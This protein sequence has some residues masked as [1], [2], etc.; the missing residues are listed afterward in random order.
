[1]LKKYFAV[2]IALIMVFTAFA[3]CSK[4]ES[5]ETEVPFGPV[6]WDRDINEHWITDEDGEKLNLGEHEL[7]EIGICAVCKSEI[8]DFGDG[9][10]EIYNYDEQGNLSR[11]SSYTS[12]NQCIDD[13]ENIFE[14]DENGNVVHLEVYQNGFLCG[15]SEFSY[16][17]EGWTYESVVV[18][19]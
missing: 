11:L 5:E 9:F 1:M 14:Y 15:E 10:I 8:I 17:S 12:D 6:K 4:E 2:L 16:S 19:H 3:G 18:F 7:D 13:C